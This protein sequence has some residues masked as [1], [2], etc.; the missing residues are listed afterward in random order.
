[1]EE[2][3]SKEGKKGEKQRKKG[4]KKARETEGTFWDARL[5]WMLGQG[6]TVGC[7]VLWKNWDASIPWDLKP[8][9][10]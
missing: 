8:Y 4:K 7:F 9:Y 5:G 6:E 1:M 2:K 10:S 3:E